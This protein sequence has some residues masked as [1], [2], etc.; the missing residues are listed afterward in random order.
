MFTYVAH[1]AADGINLRIVEH[2]YAIQKSTE[3]HFL[4]HTVAY[5][6]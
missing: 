2:V 1:V 3:Q 6:R 4:Q 5:L